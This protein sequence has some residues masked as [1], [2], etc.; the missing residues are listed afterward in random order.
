MATQDGNNK[1][2]PST[3]KYMYEAAAATTTATNRHINN[4]PVFAENL[5]GLGFL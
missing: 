4:T 1:T 2:I 5:F 3:T